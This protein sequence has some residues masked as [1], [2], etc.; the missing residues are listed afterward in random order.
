MGTLTTNEQ[1]PTFSAMA[2]QTGVQGDDPDRDIFASGAGTIR[3]MMVNNTDGGN[4]HYIKIY[5]SKEPSVSETGDAPVFV[6]KCAVS[7]NTLIYCNPGIVCSTG[8]SV[9]AG[10]GA[11]SLPGTDAGASDV[12]YTI[13]GA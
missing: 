3:A 1:N 2:K 12:T 5:D 7:T 13:F 9:T 8:V 6:F 4:V 10:R 11:G